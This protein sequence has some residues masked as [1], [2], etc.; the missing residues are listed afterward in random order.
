[1]VVRMQYFRCTR[2]SSGRWL[3]P[4]WQPLSVTSCGAVPAVSLI[5]RRSTVYSRTAAERGSSSNHAWFSTTA[6]LNQSTTGDISATSVSNRHRRLPTAIKHCSE[7]PS[8][9]FYPHMPIYR[10][11][12]VHSGWRMLRVHLSI[13]IM[14]IGLS[15]WPRAWIGWTDGRVRHAQAK[16]RAAAR[17]AAEARLTRRAGTSKAGQTKSWEDGQADGPK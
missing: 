7:A 11:L 16:R 1:M 10:L 9:H 5:C 8:A 2:T 12:F 14:I 6:S 17:A 15:R 3:A 4:S 13:Y